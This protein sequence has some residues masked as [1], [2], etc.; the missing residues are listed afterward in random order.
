MAEG[1]RYNGAVSGFFR[2]L[3]KFNSKCNRV[4]APFIGSAEEDTEYP[5]DE[6]PLAWIETLKTVADYTNADFNTAWKYTISEFFTYLAAHVKWENERKKM[7]QERH[8][9]TA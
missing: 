9:H 5:E 6:N 2:L 1:K 8:G 7:M 3:G 4:L